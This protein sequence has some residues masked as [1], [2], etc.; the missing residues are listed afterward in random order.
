MTDISNNV[1]Q[2]CEHINHA[3][4]A[5][6]R[7]PKEIT[8][9]AISKTFPV[10]AISE[11]AEAGLRRFGENRLQ[12]AEP[13]ISSLVASRAL[14]WHLVG[15][16]QS[17]KAKRAVQLVEV[18]HSVDSIKLAQ[19]LS[20]SC[21]ELEKSVSVLIQVNLGL[22][23]TKF[24]ARSEQVEEIVDQVARL[25]GLRLDGLMTIPP[26]FEN[27]DQSRPFFAQLRELRDRIES[28]HPGS[29][30]RKH[31]SMGMSHDFRVAIEEGA[32]I[33]RIGTAIFGSREAA[34]STPRIGGNLVENL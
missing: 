34:K 7:D 24:G 27:P 29:L 8:L 20:Q 14:E 12:E 17:N 33:V 22:E 28:A 23:Q 16:L 1:K 31:L 18:I 15:H 10:E 32:T 30:G 19:K 6:S 9:V 13:K 5:S 21:V 3:A 25:P 2:V 26:F 11:A 4:A